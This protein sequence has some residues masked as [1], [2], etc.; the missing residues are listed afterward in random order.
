MEDKMQYSSIDFPF[1]IGV[2]TKRAAA[3]WG[4]WYEKQGGIENCIQLA[5]ELNIDVNSMVKSIQTHS[6]NIAIVKKE[7]GGDGILRKSKFDDTDGLI[8]NQKGIAL[9]MVQSDCHPVYFYDDEKKVIGLAHSGRKGT[10][11][12]IAGKMVK[13]M[14]KVFGCKI[15][16]IKAFIGPGICKDCYVVGKDVADN[17]KKYFSS[18]IHSKIVFEDHGQYRINLS[19]S[20]YER[21][22]SAGL[23]RDQIRIS[24]LCTKEDHFYSYR[25]GSDEK[26]DLALLLMKNPDEIL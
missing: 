20:I 21:L 8:T 23:G 5:Q 6:S 22:C 16:N 10:E 24:P 1:C 7:D 19:A 15:E 13:K 14:Q 18:D 26:S 12:N 2:Y 11:E 3:Y 25:G 4:Y 17:F 9:C